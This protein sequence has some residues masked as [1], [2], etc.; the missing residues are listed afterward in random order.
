MSLYIIRIIVY[1]M[2]F[3]A[4]LGGIFFLFLLFLIIWGLTGSYWLNIAQ[5]GHIWNYS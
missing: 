3:F 5:F 2:R 1:C 4:I